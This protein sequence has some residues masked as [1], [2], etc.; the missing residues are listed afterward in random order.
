[1]RV[2]GLRWTKSKMPWPP[3]SMPVMT[4]D[5]ATGLCG[6]TVVAEAPERALLPE[7]VQVRER[8]EVGFDEDGI[9]AVHAE[10]DHALAGGARRVICARWSEE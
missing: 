1:M 10:H 7:T 8:G 4:L 9:H 2:D 6:G 3:G 5:Q